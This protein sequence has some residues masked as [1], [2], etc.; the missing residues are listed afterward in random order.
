MTY[1]EFKAAYIKA[2]NAMC[3]YTPDQVGM[4]YFADKM[5]DLADEYPDWT[6][7]VENEV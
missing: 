4:A 2:F 5:A 3:K 6:E 7:M 1:N